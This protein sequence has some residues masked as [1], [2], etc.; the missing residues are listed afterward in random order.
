MW[1]IGMWCRIMVG[2]SCVHAGRGLMVVRDGQV[3]ARRRWS[4][5]CISILFHGWAMCRR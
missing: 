3:R 5:M 1:G 2:G 4:R